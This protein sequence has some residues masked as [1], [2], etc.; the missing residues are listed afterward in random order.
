MKTMITLFAIATSLGMSPTA[1]ACG[2][3]DAH[4]KDGAKK[5]CAAGCKKKCCAEKKKC[6]ADCKK[7]CC[8]GKEAKKAE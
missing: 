7:E 1:F 5:E 8:K 4:N 3:C 6:G 2:T